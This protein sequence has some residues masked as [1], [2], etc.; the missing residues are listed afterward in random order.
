M[1]VE[2]EVVSFYSCLL[3]EPRVGEELP[4][5][6]SALMEHGFFV[7]LD[8]LYID[9]MVSAESVGSGWEFDPATHRLGWDDGQVVKVGQ[10]VTV[11]VASV[12]LQRKQIN[13]ELMSELPR[14]PRVRAPDRGRGRGAPQKHRGSDRPRGGGGGSKPQGQRPGSKPHGGGGK[15][16]FKRRR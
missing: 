1:Q 13:F 14:G 3:I 2:R 4:G 7:E 5:T 11:K 8:G 6:V 15:R 12:N 10:K 9:G 16:S